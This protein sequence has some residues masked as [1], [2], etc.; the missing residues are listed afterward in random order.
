MYSTAVLWCPPRNVR[1]VRFPILLWLNL[2]ES[3]PALCLSGDN[4]CGFAVSVCPQHP[5]PCMK[6]PVLAIREGRIMCLSLSESFSPRCLSPFFFVS[7]EGHLKEVIPI[8]LCFL[9]LLSEG[10]C[11]H[12]CSHWSA[13]R[14][15]AHK[16][17]SKGE[18]LDVWDCCLFIPLVWIAK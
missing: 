14:E 7:A 15:P 18:Q 4:R 16:R 1:S 5:Y 2:A 6:S 17:R 9:L 11:G 12:R 3:N 10:L 13:R 8:P